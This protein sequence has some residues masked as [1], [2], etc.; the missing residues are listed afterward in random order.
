MS[1]VSVITES[2][3]LYT[4]ALVKVLSP[5]VYAKIKEIYTGSTSPS[6]YQQKLLDVKDYSK[7][8][9]K[10]FYNCAQLDKDYTSRL[11]LIIFKLNIKILN[12]INDT[13]VCT[14]NLPSVKQFLYKLFV[15]VAKEMYYSPYLFDT[16]KRQSN[17]TISSSIHKRRK[18]IQE[19][20]GTTI[21]DY[22]PIK[23]ILVMP[24]KIISI[25]HDRDN[26]NE[27]DDNEVVNKNDTET[28]S[29]NLL[30][31]EQSEISN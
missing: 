20:I 4:N 27:N 13:P 28:V 17:H 29:L 16:S 26:D 1:N 8:T 3:S 12:V 2:K 11:L 23:E 15:N 5:V 18:I 30:A 22:L 21:E 19:C 9:I 14:I 24:Q 7:H 10:A 31:S 6:D 25:T